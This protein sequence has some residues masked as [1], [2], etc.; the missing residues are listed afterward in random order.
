MS[1]PTP[2]A[3]PGAGA[4]AHDGLLWRRLAKLGAAHG[5]RWFV[6][7]SPSVIGLCVALFLPAT[8]RTVR[9][10]LRR[11]RGPVGRL[12]EAR[13]VAATFT[14]YAGCL[15]E[16]LAVGS[17]NGGRTELDLV[18]REHLDR[19]LALGKGVVMVTAHTAGWELVGPVFKR[20]RGVDIV[21]VMEPERDAGARELSDAARREAGLQVAHVGHDPLASL[22]LL[23][24]L[25][26]G[27][28]VALQID[29]TPAGMRSM[30]VRVF[31]EPGA[32]PEGPLRLAQLSGAPIVPVFAAR[33]G[34]LRYAAEI[35]PP[36]LVPRRP[37]RELLEASAQELADAM[38][39]FVRRHP[40]QWF[41]FRRPPATSA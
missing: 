5:P 32:I 40:T 19:A 39:S 18:G 25:R 41:D 29:R 2:P 9:D 8:R 34:R 36:L 22:P 1:A 6:E 26:D 17:K 24:K 23:H 7:R 16:V 21:M 38:A 35:F 4:F 20:H 33:L 31:G 13:E 15:T 11:I 30:P 10:N 3:R 12:R 37:E 28:V 27:G 14:S